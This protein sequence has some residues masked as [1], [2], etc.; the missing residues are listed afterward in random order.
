[1]LPKDFASVNLF[2]ARTVPAATA[3]PVSADTTASEFTIALRIKG[4]VTL[5]HFAKHKSIEDF[6]KNPYVSLLN[7]KGKR[8]FLTS[9]L[10]TL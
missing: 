8:Y 7:M 6:Q 9:F 10:D 1:M 4:L 2:V 5:M 3:T